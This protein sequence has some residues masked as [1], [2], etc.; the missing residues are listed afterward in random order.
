MFLDQS[1]AF[2]GGAYLT[3]VP[4]A[5]LVIKPTTVTVELLIL[6]MLRSTCTRT[7]DIKQ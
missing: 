3:I 1:S 5:L 7:V 6:A 2:D 4:L